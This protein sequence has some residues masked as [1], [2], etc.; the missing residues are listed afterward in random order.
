MTPLLTAEAVTVRYGS[1]AA[2]DGVDLRVALGQ[3]HALIGPNGAGKTTLLDVLAGATRPAAGR[4]RLAG[5]D[6]TRLGPAARARRGVGRIHQ[7]PAVWGSL[8]ARENVLVAALPR[9]V[10][11]GRWHPAARRRAAGRTADALLA[12]VGLGDLAAVPAGQL[13][14][15][16]RRQVEI[17]V[18]LAGRPRLLLLDE[19][20][21]GLSAVEVGWLAEFLRGLPRA[22]AVLL[23]EHRLDLVYAL[24]DTVTVLRDGRTL[25]TGSPAE[26]RASGPVR[27]AYAEGVT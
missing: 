6:V 17:A 8:T 24:C 11:A 5:R 16:Q 18:A 20:A 10:R 15:G 2:L 3:R 4:V 1:L 14:H 22:V 25:A 13:A 7:R 26:I 19:P 23:V 9:A 12:R 21:A 27:E